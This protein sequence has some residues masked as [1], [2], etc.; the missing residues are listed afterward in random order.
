MSKPDSTSKM[1]TLVQELAHIKDELALQAHLMSMEIKD[2][3]HDLEHKINIL[4]NKWS[5]SLQEVAKQVGK[6]EEHFFVG[7]DE[8]IAALLEEFKDLKE[9]HK[10]NDREDKK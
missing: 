4:E 6:S 5:R 9:R 8:E 2:S 3:W 10:S 1:T 7:N